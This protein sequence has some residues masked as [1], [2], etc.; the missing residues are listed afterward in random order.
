MTNTGWT[1][2]SLACPR[3]QNALDRIEECTLDVL[4]RI[5]P[6]SDR[7]DGLFAQ[8]DVVPSSEDGAAQPSAQHT[9]MTSR[10]SDEVAPYIQSITNFPNCKVSQTRY[11]A[12]AFKILEQS[13]SAASTGS[14]IT[15]RDLFYRDVALFKRQTSSDAH[16]ASLSSALDVDRDALGIRA[17]A[18]GLLSGSFRLQLRQCLPSLRNS[19]SDAEGDGGHDGHQQPVLWL[20]GSPASQ[21]LV[22]FVHDLDTFQTEAAWVLVVEK[23]AIFQILCQHAF[24][25]GSSMNLKPGLI[26]TGKGYPDQATQQFLVFLAEQFKDISFFILTDGDPHGIDILRMYQYGNG[27]I[28]RPGRF[29]VP[30]LEWLGLRTADFMLA[31]PKSTGHQ[32]I[33]AHQDS[34]EG[35]EG[36]GG[37]ALVSQG[38][39][40]LSPAD[41]KKAESLISHDGLSELLKNELRIM[42]HYGGKAELEVLFESTTSEDSDMSSAGDTNSSQVR[43]PAAAA[44]ATD[45][46]GECEVGTGRKGG[47]AP[48][49]CWHRTSTSAPGDAAAGANRCQSDAAAADSFDPPSREAVS[50]ID[51][52][53]AAATSW[54]RT[55][56]A[57]A[58]SV[59]PGLKMSQ[60]TSRLL[61]Y[62]AE[63]MCSVDASVVRAGLDGPSSDQL[64]SSLHGA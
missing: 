40:R 31:G 57:S 62:V 59:D 52:V 17:A 60:A 34:A 37:E 50:A 36:E 48:E 42:L 26:I 61:Q 7:N 8:Q 2:S 15:K 51:A 16:I 28:Q 27:T 38:M 64:L 21:H 32:D 4:E 54:T 23:E 1:S 41:R 30:H 9:S 25:A 44:I 29:A 35:R 33:E 22:P 13:H 56:P 24:A 3:R 19:H 6:R 55:V 58:E 12:Q 45:G 63:R 20:E 39:L 47:G 53:A 49:E 18:K 14:F 43:G 10:R 5:F 46:V 11:Q